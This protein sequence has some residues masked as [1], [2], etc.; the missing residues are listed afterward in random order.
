MGKRPRRRPWWKSLKKGQLADLGFVKVDRKGSTIE[1]QEL[2]KDEVRR[3]RRK[4]TRAVE[5]VAKEFDAPVPLHW[6]G[7]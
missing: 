2:S 5:A 3:R 7:V 6:Q 1:W 4:Y